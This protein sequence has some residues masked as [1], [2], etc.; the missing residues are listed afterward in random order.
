MQC[1][2]HA[3]ICRK[4][5]LGYKSICAKVI[6]TVNG[7]KA[8]KVKTGGDIFTQIANVK[9]CADQRIS[10]PKKC[11]GGCMKFP[12]SKKG[13]S[14]LKKRDSQHT[15]ITDKLNSLEKKLLYGDRTG[16]SPNKR[17]NIGKK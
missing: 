15:F 5:Y 4:K 11:I 12:G 9:D 8:G 13:A 6:N 14:I 3:S 16:R 1:K 17:K 10:Y 2:L 7:L